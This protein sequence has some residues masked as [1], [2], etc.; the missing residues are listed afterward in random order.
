MARASTTVPER[1]YCSGMCP[2]PLPCTIFI[3]IWYPS[4]K[5]NMAYNTKTKYTYTAC[6]EALVSALYFWTI[7]LL[8]L[9][10]IIYDRALLCNTCTMYDMIE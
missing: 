2:L 4:H 9:Y 6:A 1:P 8:V 5:T 10:Y 3:L 7:A